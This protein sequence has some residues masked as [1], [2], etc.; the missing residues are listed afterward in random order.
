MST[1]EP[2][3]LPQNP[4]LLKLAGTAKTFT[5]ASVNSWNDVV[6]IPVPR[7]PAVPATYSLGIELLKIE[8]ELVTDAFF[9]PG[10]YSYGWVAAIANPD[11]TVAP[12]SLN[13]NGGITIA[14][15]RAI[16]GYSN[17]SIQ[18]AN[19]GASGA[20]TTFMP[21]VGVPCTGSVDLT[22]G[23]GNG[24]LF[25]GSQ[26]VFQTFIDQANIQTF[27]TSANTNYSGSSGSSFSFCWNVFYRVKHVTMSEIVQE[28]TTLLS[29]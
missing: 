10:L 28:L 11:P 26:L 13:S 4:N 5:G 27:Y 16:A 22:D 19:T 6:D 25:V 3:N 1:K 12:G 14:D 17:L 21:Q 18:Q 20:A 7:F 23:K 8:W 29:L 2:K 24:I 15:V 9:S